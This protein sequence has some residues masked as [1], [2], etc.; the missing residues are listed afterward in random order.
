MRFK[1]RF[2]ALAARAA[3][4]QQL[5]PPGPRTSP[6]SIV[7][8]AAATARVVRR[9]RRRRGHQRAPAEE[10]EEAVDEHGGGGGAPP[11]SSPPL[12]LSR[13]S[14]TSTPRRPRHDACARA[15]S[16]ADPRKKRE[17]LLAVLLQTSRTVSSLQSAGWWQ[18]VEQKIGSHLAFR[19]VFLTGTGT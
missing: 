8:A 1:L 14:P 6:L 17:G 2:V 13:T 15:P 3:T 7:A 12:P 16:A 18:K 4:R 5:N 11:S 10:V 19:L 9:R